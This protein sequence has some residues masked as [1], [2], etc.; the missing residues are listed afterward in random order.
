MVVPFKEAVVDPTFS[1]L[2]SLDNQM[3]SVV[4]SSLKP[5]EKIKKY[6]HL[7]D[8]FR[9]G[10][11]EKSLVPAED[12]ISSQPS[13][14]QKQLTKY[15]PIAV[16]ARRRLQSQI[17]KL[18]RLHK[19][20]REELD[21]I[22]LDDDTKEATDP[23]LNANLS[24]SALEE[25]EVTLTPEDRAKDIL[26]TKKKKAKEGVYSRVIQGLQTADKFAAAVKSLPSKRTRRPPEW[27]KKSAGYVK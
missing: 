11:P 17:Q 4:N 8:N 12:N 6:N 21:E 27:Y 10:V 13:I 19:S 7:L 23:S 9:I 1:Y 18:S 14:V 20:L 26:R 25:A 5:D 15:S 16:V 24:E 3:K 22:D 2:S